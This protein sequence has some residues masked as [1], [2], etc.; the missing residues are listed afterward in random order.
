MSKRSMVIFVFFF[1]HYFC[2]NLYAEESYKMSLSEI[3]DLSKLKISLVSGVDESL[4]N[5]PATIVVITAKQIKNRGYSSVD[6]ILLDLPGFDNII[7]NGPDYMTTYQRGYRTPF[8]QRTLM[9]INNKVN[10][11]LWTQVGLFSRQIPISNIKRVEVLYGGASALYGPNAFLGIVNFITKDGQ[12]EKDQHTS[13]KANILRG[14]WN[15]R[16]DEFDATGKY[17]D[18]SFSLSARTFRSDEADLS[19]KWGFSSNAKY[20]D[21]QIWG[22]LLD[23]SV[24]GRPVGSYYDPTD[25]YGVNGLFTYKKLKIGLIRFQNKEAYGPYYPS[26][27]GQ[28][29]SYW[30]KISRQTWFEYETDLNDTL[31]SKTLFSYRES[32]VF[33]EWMESW[34][35]P[36]PG[37]PWNHNISWTHW[38]SNND[39]YLF[40]QDFTVKQRGGFTFLSG[41]KYEKKHLTKAYDIP[42]YNNGNG[43]FQSIPSQANHQSSDPTPYNKQPV[44]SAKMS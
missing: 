16:L 35:N 42:G 36:L 21:R 24:N 3:F 43:V 15:T 26:D 44:P 34:S 20:S 25:D 13:F 7:N 18:L 2:S 5:S 39:A 19:S 28:N 6:E 38:N 31:H 27:R 12:D 17:G 4:I 40:Q 8:T 41:L 22:V 33:G 30:N 32:R 11:N 29:H 10:N 14:Q 23:E 37:I 9:M 1:S